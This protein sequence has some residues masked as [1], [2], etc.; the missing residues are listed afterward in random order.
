[1][2]S[3]DALVGKVVVVTGA[4]GGIG[5]ALAVGFA[6]DGATVVAVGRR[7]ATLVETATSCPRPIDR[8]V[9]DLSKTAECSRAV[10]EIVRAHGRIDVL[11]NNAGLAGS[12]A[13]LEKPFDEWAD[14]IAVNVVGVA[15]CCRAALPHMIE[16]GYGRIVT[17]TSRMAG[18]PSPGPSTVAVLLSVAGAPCVT[19]TGT[20]IGG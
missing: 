14:T 5:R 13:F 11:I 9:A 17:I 10:E 4:G 19:R 2:G 8:V 3:V 16:R 12:G 18:L 7:E 1:M 20:L 15:A 6:G